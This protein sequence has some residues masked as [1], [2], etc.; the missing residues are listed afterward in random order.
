MADGSVTLH[1]TWRGII[2]SAIGSTAVLLAGVLVVASAGWRLLP[3][4]TLAFGV[5]LVA[6]V[7]FDY[8][9]ASTFDADGV[10]RHMVLRRH[11]LAWDRVDKLSRTRPGLV[12]GFR[13]L[14]YGGL[15]AVVGRRRY[16]LT[17]RCESLEEYGAVQQAIGA[18]AEDLM[19][20]T[21]EPPA[22]S[23][24]TWWYRRRKWAPDGAGHR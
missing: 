18:R 11:R 19:A 15:V 24:P 12:S 3:T 22:G 17:D 20:T 10:T 6:I 13:K 14:A 4:A 2:A 23:V 5:A 9:V 8:P 21:P 7:L 16:L 1:S